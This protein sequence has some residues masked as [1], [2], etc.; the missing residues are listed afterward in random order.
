MN[1]IKNIGI[2]GGGQLARMLSMSCADLGF[3][4]HIYCP[5]KN[6]PAAQVSNSIFIGDYTDKNKL[7]QFSKSLDV[8]TYEFENIDSSGLKAIEKDVTIFPPVRSLEVSQDRYLEKNFLYSLGIRT[9]PFYKIDN[10]SDIE[11]LVKK[12]GKKFLIKTRKYGYDGKNQVLVEDYKNIRRQFYKKLIAPSIAEE[13]L[14]FDK[15][16]SII[17]ARDAKGKIK[18]FEPAENNH[19]NGILFSSSVPA[20]ISRKIEN[21]AVSISKK[22]AK[23][24]NYIGVI[25]VE[26]FLK[27]EGL[28]VNEFAPRVHNSGH[29]TLDASNVSQFDQHIRAISGIPLLSPERYADVE[30]Y[31]LIG[32]VDTK[33]KLHKN[34]KLYLYGKSEILPGRKMGHI[35]IIK[36]GS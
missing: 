15:E 35:N 14:D 11:L 30:M 34:S 26:F 16:I 21:K 23:T 32:T 17:L 22:I 12:E 5:E 24:L 31:N 3:N 18:T 33:K 9:A 7:R 27:N 1:Q 13:V 36:K 28:Y 6:C 8:L 20:K 25:G 2:I 4:A 10:V 19:K 29:W